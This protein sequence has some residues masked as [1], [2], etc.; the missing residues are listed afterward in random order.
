MRKLRI[1]VLVHENLVPPES[2]DGVS[3]REVARWRDVW[4]VTSTLR[5]IGH[6]VR[7][8]GL[9]DELAPL[10]EV[11]LEWRPPLAFNLMEEFSGVAGYD[12]HVAA[13]LELLGSDR[14]R[15][16]IL[17]AGYLSCP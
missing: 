12:A 3:E 5:E 7:S 6:E 8:L 9:L 16:L 10:R 11:L 1:L 4:D 13:Y 17:D 2:L 14:V 15:S